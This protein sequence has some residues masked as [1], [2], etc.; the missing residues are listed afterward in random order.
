MCKGP[1]AVRKE[2]GPGEREGV[3]ESSLCP[4]AGR[5][6]LMGL[7]R[8]DRARGARVGGGRREGKKLLLRETWQEE[9]GRG[10]MLKMPTAV[11]KQGKL[12]VLVSSGRVWDC[13]P[14]GGEGKGHKD[15]ELI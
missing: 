13:W 3:K 12:K 2:P 1:A 4:E 7:L 15:P 5:P 9:V 10:A 8:G 11:T 14:S 6:S